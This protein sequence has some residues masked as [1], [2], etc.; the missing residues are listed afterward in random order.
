MIMLLFI[1][2]TGNAPSA[3][4][5]EDGQHLMIAMAGLLAEHM[6]F[7][8]TGEEDEEA[9]PLS[10]GTNASGAN[11]LPLCITRLTKLEQLRLAGD[12]RRPKVPFPS[13]PKE[14]EGCPKALLFLP[15]PDQLP[16]YEQITAAAAAQ[17]WL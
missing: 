13:L 15:C 6:C 8:L 9:Q 5:Y 2:N 16:L 10:P 4:R 1:R 12:W 14:G 11:M 3:F 7:H 17:T